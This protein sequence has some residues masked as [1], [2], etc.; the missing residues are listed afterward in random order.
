MSST[1]SAIDP[2][3]YTTGD[4][5]GYR[6]R[7]RCIDAGMGR[8][9][10]SV[11]SRPKFKRV[12]RLKDRRMKARKKAWHK[13]GLARDKTRRRRRGK[14]QLT[15]ERPRHAHLTCIVSRQPPS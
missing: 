5:P 10:R 14:K 13:R 3:R 11:K 1:G 8:S 6:G 2:V 12:R 7:G 4:R 9:K 15:L